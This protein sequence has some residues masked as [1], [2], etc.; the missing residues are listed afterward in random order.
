MI[1]LD[2]S[3]EIRGHSAF[4]RMIK[5]NSERNY[6]AVTS[7][8]PKVSDVVRGPPPSE[9]GTDNRFLSS[10]GIENMT[11][12]DRSTRYEPDLVCYYSLICEHSVKFKIF[13][14]KMQN[15]PFPNRAI[16]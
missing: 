14:Q 13:L 11:D 4:L 3:V 5:E 10:G 16:G 9:A 12:S 6:M 7:I 2:G 15:C 1:G 8:R